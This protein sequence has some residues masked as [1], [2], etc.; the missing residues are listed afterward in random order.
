MDPLSPAGFSPVGSLLPSLTGSAAAAPAIIELLWGARAAIDTTAFLNLALVRLLAPFGGNFS[1]LWKNRQGQWQIIAEAGQRAHLPRE[2]LSEALDHDQPV[3]RSPWVLVGL[4]PYG[5]ANSVLCL[6]LG[7]RHDLPTKPAPATQ[8]VRGIAAALAAGLGLIRERRA[9]SRRAERLLTMLQLAQEWASVAQ[10]QPLLVHMAEASTRLLQADRA[11]IFL[12]D[13]GAGQLVARPALG[14]PGGELRIPDEVGIVGKTLRTGRPQRVSRQESAA[15]IHRDVDRQLN[16]QT[17][18]L[19]AV[20]LRAANGDLLGVFEVINK[21]VGDFDDE[22]EGT[23]VELA[24][25]AAAALTNTQ[26]L[27]AALSTSQFL[28]EQAAENV[29]LLGN[30]PAILALQGT[31]QRV[32]PTELVVLLTG[33]NG[34]GK[35]VASRAIHYQSRRRNHPW[36]AVNCAALTE[37]LLESE[38]FGHE[39]GAFTDAVE[40]RPGKFELA[41]GGTLFLD[42]IAELSK[43][44]QAKLLRVL[45]E[46]LVV[47]VGG[48][49]PITTDVRV[50]AA[51]NQNLADLVRQKRFREDLYYRLNVVS[52]ELPPLRER[53]EDIHLLAEHFLQEFCRRAGR[54]TPRFLPAARQR[55]EQHPWPGNVRELRN[56]MERLAFLATGEKI[57]PEDVAFILSPPRTGATPQ[58]GEVPLTDATWQ[59]QV[60]Y[61]N[62]ALEKTR[63][64]M[65]AAAELLGL[66]RSNL[67]RKMKQLGMPTGGE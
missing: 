50:I 6:R 41:N 37:T 38:L 7:E 42:E 31:L 24:G 53:G 29:R 9:A 59:F 27:E 5:E 13:R 40:S 34:T 33:E 65:S 8:Y 17:H 30:S 35:E 66:H 48:S 63:G 60:Q 12:W 2:L 44:G 19:V 43:G 11:S 18:S 46:K 36:V 57:A 45:E 49:R 22:D 25:Q 54:K 61:I 47:R 56:L 55:L 51:T 64:N 21:L 52:L 28:V 15:E 14:V 67:Y 10:V 62:Q 20:P 39:K 1:S 4:N 3:W 58:V 26:Q 32:A 16:Y 23:L